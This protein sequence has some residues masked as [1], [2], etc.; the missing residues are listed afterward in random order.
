MQR[1]LQRC[2]IGE[3]AFGTVEKVAAAESYGGGS[4]IKQGADAADD[5]SSGRHSGASQCYFLYT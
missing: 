4:S 3:Q 1:R 5:D 2:S